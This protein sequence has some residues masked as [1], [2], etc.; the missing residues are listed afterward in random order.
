MDEQGALIFA[1]IMMA[2]STLMP[3]I[4]MKSIDLDSP[5]KLM[6]YRTPWS[7]KSK[8][9][10]RYANSKSAEYILWMALVTITIQI[11]TFFLLDP[12]TSIMIAAGA[13]I[14]GLAAVMII[15]EKGL[16]KNFDKDGDPR[17]D[18]DRF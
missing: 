9:T 4:I 8:H 5:N 11:A 10:W 15:T 12:L 18:A 7:M 13:L 2:V 3:G 14:L 1:H 6:G 16:R 17:L